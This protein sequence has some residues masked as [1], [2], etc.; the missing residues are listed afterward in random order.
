MNIRHHH[1]IKVLCLFVC[2]YVYRC[3]ASHS[4]KGTTLSTR[5]SLTASCTTTPPG[6]HSVPAARSQSQVRIIMMA[7]SGG[8]RGLIIHISVIV[9]V[10]A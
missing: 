6:A 2:V 9:A 5:G 3:V 8:G 4:P 1:I 10:N 7:L